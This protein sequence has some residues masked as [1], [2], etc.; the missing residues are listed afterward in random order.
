MT[1]LKGKRCKAGPESD[2]LCPEAFL[3]VVADKLAYTSSMFI[4]IELLD[5]FFYQFPRE[6]DS[7]LLYDLDRSE[8]ERFARENPTVRRHLEL[9]ER[10]DKLEEVRF[11]VDTRYVLSVDALFL[12]HEAPQQSVDA[13]GRRAA[14]TAPTPWSVWR[15]VLRIP[16]IYHLALDWFCYSTA[17]CLLHCYLYPC[18]P[19][20]ADNGMHDIQ[21]GTGLVRADYP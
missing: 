1:A 21:P 6:I 11:R 19:T 12:G 5:Q 20:H 4:N 17:L 2:L 15:H 7:R 3:E 8:I 18:Y 10:K 13:Q 9:Q 16:Y 14:C